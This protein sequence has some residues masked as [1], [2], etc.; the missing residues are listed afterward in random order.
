MKKMMKQ[1]AM[2]TIPTEEYDALKAN[3]EQMQLLQQQ[4][5]YLLEQV[6]LAKHRQFGAS[7]EKSE[8]DHQIN[9]F[10]EAETY[11]MPLAAEPE[12][13]E[14]EKHVRRKRRAQSDRLPEDLPV[15]IV[16]YVLPEEEQVC[17]VC[18]EPL[19]VMGK[20]TVRRELKLIPAKAVI[21]EHVRYAYAC[22]N[23]EKT[24]TDAGA[25]HEGQLRFA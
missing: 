17:P 16:E 4:V 21:V 12:L 20:E 13:C 25:G 3:T 15:E 1:D 8:Y 24:S 6:R 19:H 11:A 9:L 10:D 22:R 5:D 18:K 14:V 2:V 23:C 7:S